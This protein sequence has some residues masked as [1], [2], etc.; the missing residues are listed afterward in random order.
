MPS[1]SQVLIWE[2]QV[3]RTGPDSV[4][5]TAKQPLDTLTSAQAAKV[6]GCSQWTVQSLFQAGLLKGYKPGARAVRRDGRASNASL[7]L[8]SASV[9]EYR[10][11]QIGLAEA[12][13]DT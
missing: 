10:R 2:S 6:L 7:R 5:I 1:K 8:D 11:R 4:S 3:T 13:R 12:E 9:A